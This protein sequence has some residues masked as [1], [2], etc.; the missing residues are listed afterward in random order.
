MPLQRGT[1]AT[2]ESAKLIHRERTLVPSQPTSSVE[3]RAPVHDED[4]EGDTQENG[5]GKDDE[6]GC[7]DNVEN[8]IRPLGVLRPA[9]AFWWR[10]DLGGPSLRL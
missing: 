9:R 7:Q 2:R 1:R 5:R 6:K 10:A 8:P 3:N 4:Q